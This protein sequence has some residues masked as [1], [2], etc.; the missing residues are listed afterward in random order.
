MEGFFEGDDRRF[1]CPGCGRLMDSSDLR[2]GERF[3]CAKCKKLMRL[4]PQLFDPRYRASWQTGRMVL[5]VACIGATIWCV[6]VGYGFGERTGQWI[7]GFGGSLVV[8]ALAL[9]CIGLAARTTQNN[10]VLVGVAALMAGV[11][12]F[13]LQR[14]GER[15]GYP[16]ADWRE[17]QFF[18]LWVPGLVAIG[19]VLLVG[20]LIV[21]QRARSL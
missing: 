11:S 4:G 20:A 9:A 5:L 13:F 19:L 7:A 17:F 8:W 6:T 10:G 1:R 12:L 18:D 21:Q 14:L 16:V 2:P 15:L 3:K